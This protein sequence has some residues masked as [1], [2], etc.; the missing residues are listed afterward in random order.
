MT[1]LP[2]I[3]PLDLP[4]R[5]D[6]MKLVG[7]GAA[8]AMLPGCKPKAGAALRF[9][10]PQEATAM[11][12]LADAIFPPDD[13]PGGAA[14][15]AVTYID[16]LLSAFDSSPPEIFAGGPYSNR[17]PYPNPDGTASKQHPP[18]SLTT[19]LPLD[20]YAEAHWRLYLYGSDAVGGGPNDA[21]IGKTIGLRDQVRNGL[22][23]VMSQAT[24]S[25]D[26]QTPAQLEDT[27][28]NMD[29]TFRGTLI[30]LVAQGCLSL[31][32][33]HG[34][35]NGGGWKICHYEG[36]VQPFGFTHYDETTHQYVETASAPTSTPNPGTDPDPMDDDAV[37]LINIAITFL[38]GTTFNQ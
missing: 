3:P 36:D 21:V 38:G 33:Y 30:S 35:L 13:Q 32:E 1:P 15:G 29:P 25:L 34:N 10:T 37:N 6:F 28:S 24:T 19:F 23:V 26:K 27:I 5:R 8:A 7:L 17:N 9:F 4:G 31:P 20:R 12:A 16:H 2:V 22:Q 18:D 11:S 14:L